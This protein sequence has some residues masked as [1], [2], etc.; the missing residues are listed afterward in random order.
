MSA[1]EQL[2]EA[3]E[4]GDVEAVGRALAAGADPKARIRGS[5]KHVH[6]DEVPLTAVAAHRGDVDVL[7][8]L[9]DAGAHPNAQCVEFR[10]YPFSD[11]DV[12]FHEDTAL[13]VAAERG[14]E[15]V[16]ELLLARG[17]KPDM[18]EEI[19]SAAK[20]GNPRIVEALLAAGAP[21]NRRNGDAKTALYY[22]DKAGHE[23][24][25]EVL[26]AAGGKTT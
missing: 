12:A 25:V 5:L 11:D 7:A 23:G 8:L 9:L 2:R 16:V 10:C 26:I 21:V 18:Y 19:H 15:D 4:A 24:A 1:D 17:A 20:G 22:A 6:R 13:G 3:V 14:H